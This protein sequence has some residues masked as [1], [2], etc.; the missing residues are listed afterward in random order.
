VNGSRKNTQGPEV[1][2]GAAIGMLMLAII[3]AVTSG[4]GTKN[5]AA[6]VRITLILEY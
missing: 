2:H 6:Q 4:N 3:T 5:I 1:R